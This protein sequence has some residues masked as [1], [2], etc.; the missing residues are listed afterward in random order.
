MY[1]ITFDEVKQY[2]ESLPSDDSVAGLCCSSGKCLI[3]EA[4]THKYPDC[5]GVSVCPGART[6]A[7]IYIPGETVPY[8][9]G[10][11]LEQ[12]RME[13]LGRRFDGLGNWS[14]TATKREVL[15]LF[16]EGR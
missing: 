15:P 14:H 13:R 1:S 5:T 2:V 11:G 4:I 8:E 7:F 9:V 16:E 10:V 12:A 6:L 3:A